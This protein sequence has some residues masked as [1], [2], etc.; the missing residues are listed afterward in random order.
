[1]T[2]EVTRRPQPATICT[3]KMSDV[4]KDGSLRYIV[5]SRTRPGVKH[6]VE[7]EHYNFNGICSCESFT[8]NL[9]KYLKKGM[10]AE[11]VAK[12]RLVKL[13]NKDRPQDSLRCPHLVDAWMQWAVDSARVVVEHEKK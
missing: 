7:L 9:E 13:K 3:S 5:T 8:M 1:M 12:E 2:E 6:L 10:T 11:Y 4:K